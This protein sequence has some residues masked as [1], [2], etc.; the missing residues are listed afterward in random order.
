VLRVKITKDQP[1]AIAM[2]YHQVRGAARIVLLLM[3]AAP[4]FLFGPLLARDGSFMGRWEFAAGASVE[5]IECQGVPYVAQ[6]CQ[7]KF[8]NPVSGRAVQ[9]DYLLSGDDWSDRK[10]DVVRSANGHYT[11]SIAVT[12]KGMISRIGAF[13]GLF[14][15]GFLLEQL[16]LNMYFQTLRRGEPIAPQAPQQSRE[17]VALSRDRR[18]HL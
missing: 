8:I 1:P 14:L 7:L 9:L 16:F 10:P 6:Y 5:P 3:M 4:M 2:E 18:D 12:S 15:L 17:T 13:L 11:S